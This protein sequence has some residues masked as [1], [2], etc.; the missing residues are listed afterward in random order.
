MHWGELQ[1]H[2]GVDISD[3]H[4]FTTASDAILG[5]LRFRFSP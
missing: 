1:K 5:C 2:V 3:Y 4:P